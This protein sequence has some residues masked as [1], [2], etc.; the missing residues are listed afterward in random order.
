MIVQQLKILKTFSRSKVAKE[1]LD[2]LMVLSCE[3]DV[4]DKV[5]LQTVTQ[6]WE[7]VRF[8]RIDIGLK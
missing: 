6:V 8:K 1:R 4:T 7:N 5:N 3:K 2:D